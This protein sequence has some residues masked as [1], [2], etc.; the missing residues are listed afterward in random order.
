MYGISF[1]DRIGTDVPYTIEG[2]TISS[3]PC[4]IKWVR[5]QFT[6]DLE[7]DVF[8]PNEYPDTRWKQSRIRSDLEIGMKTYGKT[9]EEAQLSSQPLMG[10]IR[11][12][13][14]K[15]YP[16]E[17]LELMHRY[18]VEQSQII[19]KKQQTVQQ[20]RQVEDELEEV[21]HHFDRIM[22]SHSGD[23][24]LMNETI[25][26]IKRKKA[27][28]HECHKSLLVQEEDFQDWYDGIDKHA[29]EVSSEYY[30]KNHHV[31]YLEE[32]KLFDYPILFPDE[33]RLSVALLNLMIK[34]VA[35]LYREKEPE[36]IS[37]KQLS[38][39]VHSSVANFPWAERFLNTWTKS[40]QGYYEK[41]IEK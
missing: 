21:Q 34:E 25:A 33:K 38:V 36:S 15:D 31:I 17:K 24:G 5:N 27:I 39:R 22:W 8:F 6:N 41:A 1:V 7:F 37:T 35:R 19:K 26:Q 29:K 28:L 3:L 23:I 10:K 13:L 9:I 20:R 14:T 4:S 2:I 30:R 32:C 16:E 12:R 11:A 40:D 18:V